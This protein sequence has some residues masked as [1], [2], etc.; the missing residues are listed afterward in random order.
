MQAP[1]WR[2]AFFPYAVVI[3]DAENTADLTPL[4][5]PTWRDVKITSKAGRIRDLAWATVRLSD[6]TRIGIG[7]DITERRSREQTAEERL[8]STEARNRRLEQAMQET[9]H[10][11]K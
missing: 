1:E 2:L 8:A 6:G 9:D 5:A 11:V 10:R 7:Q 3:G 4:P